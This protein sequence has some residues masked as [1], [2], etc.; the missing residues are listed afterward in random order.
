MQRRS[1]VWRAVGLGAF[2]QVSRPACRV[3]G[4][5]S[6]GARARG[7]EQLVVWGQPQQPVLTL[8]PTEQSAQVWEACRRQ[9]KEMVLDFSQNALFVLKMNIKC[10]CRSVLKGELRTAARLFWKTLR[11]CH[12]SNGN[13]NSWRHLEPVSRGQILPG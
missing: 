3:P 2:G 12:S 1:Y 7:Q 8:S 6:S 13:L 5:R 11:F 4:K 9:R 10:S